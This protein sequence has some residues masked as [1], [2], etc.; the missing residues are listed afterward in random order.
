SI[1]GDGTSGVF[2]EN[3]LDDFKHWKSLAKDRVTLNSFDIL[4]ANP[5]FGKDIKV[6]GNFLKNYDLALRW[7]LEGK[8][9][10]K[11]GTEYKKSV[12]PSILFLEQCYNLLK[13]G[14]SFFV[15]LPVGDLSNKEDY[16]IHHWLVNNMNVKSI[17]QLPS[18]TFQP[19]CGTQVC[20][21]HAE[22]TKP[23]NS[24]VFMALANKVGKNQRGKPLYKRDIYG[25]LF[26]ENG[27]KVIDDD[28]VTILEDYKNF[29]NK[30]FKFSKLSFK[31]KKSD[32]KNKLL[33]N[34]HKP[35]LLLDINEEKIIKYEKL[36]DLC[37]E[38]YTPPR[39]ARIYV[40]K[41]FGVPFL[42]GSNITQYI[43]QNLKFISRSQTKDL[44]K[45]IV[46]TGDIVITRVGTMGI[47]RLISDDLD[48]YAVSDNINIIRIDKNKIDPEYIYAM[49]QSNFGFASLSKIS[50]GS[51]QHYN[52][53]KELKK[54]DIPIYQ[55]KIYKKIVNEIKLSE[56]NR[57]N[58][59]N[60]IQNLNLTL[61]DI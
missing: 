40:G 3:S 24:E 50:K 45:Y 31:V 29:E 13:K 52:D 56:S 53:P 26:L 2:C 49:L 51:V 33:P 35:N 60:I 30:T 20:L 10:I 14:G 12:R 42:S 4:F 48:N 44:N 61:I 59:I 47:I 1:V 39:T 38:I 6:K 18:E 7:S 22:K 58:A 55:N 32:L 27:K 9:S 8:D 19:Y 17:I 5:P 25:E 43:P 34:Y 15:I 41:E 37:I 28:L 36:E 57:I 23:D 16:N 11:I 21:L 54:I 46:N